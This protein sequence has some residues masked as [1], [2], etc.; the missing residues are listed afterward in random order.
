[1]SPAAFGAAIASATEKLRKELMEEFNAKAE[2]AAKVH[3]EELKVVQAVVADLRARGA[4]SSPESGFATPSPASKRCRR[5]RSLSF[6][7]DATFPH[8]T[9]FGGSE[10]KPVY[11]VVVHQVMDSTPEFRLDRLFDENSEVARNEVLEKLKKVFPNIARSE[12]EADLKRKCTNKNSYRR[13]AD[14]AD[15]MGGQGP[16]YKRIKGVSIKEEQKTVDS[17]TVQ[18]KET[19]PAP[20][21]VL[22][23]TPA[24]PASPASKA[25]PASTSAD[26]VT[27]PK[28][29]KGAPQSYEAFGSNWVLMVCCIHSFSFAFIVTILFCRKVGSGWSSFPPD[30]SCC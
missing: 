28:K 13:R 20:A 26:I 1:M 16:L 9:D 21:V 18:P 7:P 24:I 27:S 8:L 2:S 25:A 3:A 30:A 22:T 19:A 4:A 17:E 12:L 29:P 6:N 11:K 15:E 5:K 23:A 14:K 10:T